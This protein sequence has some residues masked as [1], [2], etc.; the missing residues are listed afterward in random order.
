MG[1]LGNPRTG[2][3]LLMTMIMCKLIK[4]AQAQEKIINQDKFYFANW[5]FLLELKE[6]VKHIEPHDLM[7][8]RLTLLYSGVV[9][10]DELWAWLES[11]GSGSS[12]NNKI[13]SQVAFQSG[14]SGYDILWSAQLSSSVDKRIRLLTDYF[15]VT[16]TP[17]DQYFKYAFVSARGVH[18]FKYNRQVASKY[19]KYYDTQERI[20]PLEADSLSSDNI[21]DDDAINQVKEISLAQ[22]D[23]EMIL[24]LKEEIQREVTSHLME[25]IQTLNEKLEQIISNPLLRM[26]KVTEF[27][28]KDRI[29]TI[30]VGK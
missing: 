25:Q 14:K 20:M 5:H 22:E 26:K 13:L 7:S 18:K 1:V 3:T 29:E 2:K 16:L 28:E 12:T 8:I 6:L 15:F 23:K 19:Y 21:D 11:R 30:T 24:T 4:M 9:G 17:N 27:V 10:L